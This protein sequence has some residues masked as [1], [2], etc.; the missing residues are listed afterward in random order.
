MKVV[1]NALLI[2]G[3]SPFLH[4]ATSLLYGE[5]TTR[6]FLNIYLFIGSTRV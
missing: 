1:E 2:P 5:E 4:D 3:P 6:D